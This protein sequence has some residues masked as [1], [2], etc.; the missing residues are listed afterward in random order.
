[1]NA[2]VTGCAGF[3]GSH[4]TQ[5][6]LA[7]GHTV[8]GVDCLTD[9][10][11]PTLKRKN[12]RHFLDNPRFSLIEKDAAELEN[13]DGTKVIFHLAARP[14]VRPSWGDKFDLYVQRNILTTARMLELAKRTQGLARFVFAS[15][16]SVYGNTQSPKLREDDPLRPFSPYGVTKLAGE[17]LCRTYAENFNLPIIA[18][19]FFTVYGPRQR[20]DMAFSRLIHSALSTNTFKVYGDGNQERDF[21][22]VGDAV[23]ALLL[24]AQGPVSHGFFNVGGERTF[25]LNKVI[26]LLE[27]IARRK[28]QVQY[29][30]PLPGDVKRT[31]ADTSLI[32][33]AL[34]YKPSTILEDGLRLQF[35]YA[36][37][38]TPPSA[39]PVVSPV[40][41]P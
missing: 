23:Q 14:G 6:L 28:L 3:I 7:T 38:N 18:L 34:G 39:A 1:M 22:Y 21:T 8:T 17:A 20:P 11:D 30:E 19:R 12:L 10:Y 9:Y 25:S 35:E 26:E 24:A 5:A 13:I 40:A 41:T 2:L 32:R 29:A 16:S 31:S 15:S 33:A 27:E 37:T 36:T 4:L